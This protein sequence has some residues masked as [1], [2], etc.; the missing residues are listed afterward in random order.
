MHELIRTVEEVGEKQ[1]MAAAQGA[2]HRH[3]GVLCRASAGRGEFVSSAERSYCRP[4]RVFLGGSDRV[5]R[6]RIFAA[7]LK[8]VYLDAPYVPAFI[9]VP[10]EF[11]DCEELEELLSER[12]G[13]RVEIHTPRRGPKKR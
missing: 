10:V 4:S 1:K 5:R 6:G 3:P 12:R 7:L 13:R 9:H 8:Q 2:G 11:E